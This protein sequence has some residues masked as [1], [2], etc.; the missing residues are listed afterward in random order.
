MIFLTLIWPSSFRFD[1]TF[2]KNVETYHKG[3]TIKL[4]V[5]QAVRLR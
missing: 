5:E 2:H 1:E 3:I 4:P